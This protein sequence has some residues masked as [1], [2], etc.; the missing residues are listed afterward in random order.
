MSRSR[1][2]WM[3]FFA[4]LLGAGAAVFFFRQGLDAYQANVAQPSLQQQAR[5]AQ[6]AIKLLGLQQISLA[7]AHLKDA[8]LSSIFGAQGEE[9]KKQAAAFLASAIGAA[10]PKTAEKLGT[11]FAALSDE[12]AAVLAL[13]AGAP[14]GVVLENVEASKDGNSSQGV[15]VSN[16]KAYLLVH[17]PVFGVPSTASAPKAGDGDKKEGDGDK[18]AGDGDKKEEDG[19]KKEGDGDKEEDPPTPRKK[20]SNANKQACPAGK[21][22]ACLKVCAKRDSKKKCLEQKE[23]C[24]CYAP[25][26]KPKSSWRMPSLQQRFAQAAEDDKPT[27]APATTPQPPVALRLLG[28]FTQAF[29]ID[30]RFAYVLKSPI[31]GTAV[32]LVFF[33]PKGQILGSSLKEKASMQTLLASAT[34]KFLL[35]MKKEGG[36][37]ELGSKHYDALS[38]KM[39]GGKI[40]LVV[41]QTRSG[42]EG[43]LEQNLILM[44]SVVVGFVLLLLLLLLPGAGKTDKQLF[45]LEEQLLDIYRTGNLQVAFVESAPGAVGSLA[46]TLNRIFFQLHNQVVEIQEA[47]VQDIPR[48][49]ETTL[50]LSSP[51]VQMA[52]HEP[53]VHYQQVFQRYAKAKEQTGE[54]TSLLDQE[55]F[56]DKLRQNAATFRKQYDCLGVAFDV[57]VK[58]NKV[59]LKPQLIPRD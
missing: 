23:K 48:Q 53:E 5:S 54:D 52:L 28:I 30:D 33:S 20:S 9:R 21:I 27:P 13:S 16:G 40:G 35:E 10:S 7:S 32:D 42:W 19:G 43:F 3:L 50:S 37:V 46:A 49:H 2:V 39:D 36:A 26:K 38:L 14:E 4:L 15:I 12:K 17:V 6:Q 44:G 51:E 22:W 34:G 59:I 25:K 11:S 41:L 24:A 56:L 8:R 45:D 31:F 18:K 58:D 29:A 55:R 47:S 57:A 1:I